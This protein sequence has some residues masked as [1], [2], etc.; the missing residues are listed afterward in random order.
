[1]TL[2]TPLDQRGYYTFKGFKAAGWASVDIGELLGLDAI[3]EG[4]FTA[5]TEAA[6]L[7]IENQ[8][9]YYENRSERMPVLFGVRIPTFGLLDQLAFEM[10]HHKSSFSNTNG[11]VLQSQLP[12]PINFGENPYVYDLTDPRYVDPANPEYQSSPFDSASYQ[13]VSRQIS[14]GTWKWTVYARRHLSQ[15]LSLYAQAASDHLRHFNFTATPAALPATNKPSD[16]YYILRL[17]FGI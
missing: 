12:I 3:P 13:R 6:L 14:D 8:P 10:E 11:S 2:N 17:E 9:Y 1:L 4:T 15:G 7:G 5:Y 16:W